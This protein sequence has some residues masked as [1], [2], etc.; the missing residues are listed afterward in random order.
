MDNQMILQMMLPFMT[1]GNQEAFAAFQEVAELQQLILS[2][3]NRGGANWQIEMLNA[4]RPKLPK[5]NRHMVD[6]MIKCI[7]LAAL[8]EKGRA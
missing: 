4:I 6:V 1:A 8:L 2:H 7:E 5:K 3:A